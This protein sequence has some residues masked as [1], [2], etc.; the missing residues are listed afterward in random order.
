MKEPHN[1]SYIKLSQIALYRL[2]II[3][4]FLYRFSI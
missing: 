3:F 4:L 2:R 1:A